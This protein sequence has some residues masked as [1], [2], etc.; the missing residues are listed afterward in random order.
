MPVYERFSGKSPL[1]ISIP[2]DGRELAPDMPE[3]M[4]AVGLSLPD[5]DW[6]VR[7]LYEFARK[8][9]VGIIAANFS[10]YVVDLNR[11]NTGE[12]L[13][14]GVESSGICPQQTFSGEAIYR[15]GRE[16]DTQEQKL[17]LENYWHPYHAAIRKELNRLREEF[18]YALL[19]D[20]HSICT[21]VPSLF[22]GKLPALNIGTN[23]GASC[24][25]ALETSVTGVAVK[26]GFSTILNGRFKG[27][28]ITRNHGSPESQIHAIQLELGQENYMN[29]NT[30]EYDEALASTLR[31][32]LKSMMMAFL[33]EAAAIH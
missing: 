7:R 12:A 22:S 16:P 11:G 2:H 21:R 26:S 30:G 15:A 32:T 1:L 27:G 17:R 3:R 5:T 14:P 29:E 9:N 24:D 6:H 19:W 10:R 18:G 33:S 23:S 20:A 13:Y 25:S 4:S 28:Y 8:L 31:I